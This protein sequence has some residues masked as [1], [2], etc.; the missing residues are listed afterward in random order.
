MFCPQSKSLVEVTGYT[1]ED[2]LPCIKDLHKL[3]LD[4]PQ[5]AQQAVREKYKGPKYVGADEQSIAVFILNNL[6]SYLLQV[7]GN[8]CH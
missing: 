6:C 3:Y 8:F 5:H 7:H 2:L 1:L 4:A